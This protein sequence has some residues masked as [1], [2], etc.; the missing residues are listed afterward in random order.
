MSVYV[1]DMRTSATV[2]NGPRALRATWSHLLADSHNELVQFA[3]ALDLRRAWI[4]HP[5]SALEHYDITDS[6]RREALRRGA[7]AI[8]LPESGYLT[9]CKR[10][11]VAFD[12]TQLRTDPA[13]VDEILAAATVPTAPPAPQAEGA[14]GPTRIQVSTAPATR[15]ALPA[16]AML[17][18]SPSKW[19]NPY[20]PQ[21]RTEAAAL[22]AVDAYRDY[23]ARNPLLR[24]HAR[25]EL[26]GKHL[27]C[28]CALWRPC[29]VDVLLAVANDVQASVPTLE[30][31]S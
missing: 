17:V 28:T 30:V 23:L 21:T 26:A 13:V 20:Q 3:A 27:A 8:T 5:G 18:T 6:K 7:I 12:I 25:K 2:R 15:E 11:G 24:E 10:L 1:D 22:A 29:H 19:A 31:Q 16:G 9:R 4:Q 14:S